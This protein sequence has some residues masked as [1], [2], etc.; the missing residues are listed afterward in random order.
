MTI[1]RGNHQEFSE[2]QI[3]YD[4][5]LGMVWVSGLTPEKFWVE[6]EYVQVFDNP[7]TFVLNYADKLRH[8]GFHVDVFDISEED[9]RFQESKD[10]EYHEED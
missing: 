10:D 8:E 9:D 1:S 6:T 2:Y 7:T 5:D 4:V 3:D